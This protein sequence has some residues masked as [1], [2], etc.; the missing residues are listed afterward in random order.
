MRGSRRSGTQEGGA[1]VPARLR[2]YARPGAASESIAW[3]PWRNGWQVRVRAPAV[4]GEANRALLEALARW[5]EVGAT[6]LRWLHGG[7]SSSKTA[8]VLGLGQEEADRRLRI[9]AGAGGAAH[10]S[11]RRAPVGE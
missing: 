3:D 7:T 8:E 6:Q 1:A 4:H 5:L 2:I 11:S 9:A 10:T